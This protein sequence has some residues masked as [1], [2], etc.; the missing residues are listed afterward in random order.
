MSAPVHIRL[1]PYG[2]VPFELRRRFLAASQEAAVP[3]HFLRTEIETTRLAAL[4]DRVLLTPEEDTVV[5]ALRIIEPAIERIAFLAEGRRANR[6]VFLKLSNIE[7]RLPLGSLGDGLKRLLALCLNL[8]PAKGGVLLVDEID[9]GLHFSVMADMWRLVIDTA[10]RLNVQV[11]ATT[12]SLDCVRALAWV[13]ETPLR[14][15]PDVSLHRI[16][17]GAARTIRYNLDEIATAAKQ[18]LEVR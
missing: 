15:A 11:F 10:A 8:V 18:H 16:E 3:V 4:W 1:S 9:T 6:S 14:S 7:D 5:E 12:H 17:R 2:G 13:R